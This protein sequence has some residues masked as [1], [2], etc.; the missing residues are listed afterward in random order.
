MDL[1][2]KLKDR[3]SWVLAH[4]ILRG[5][6]ILF[7]VLTFAK[8]ECDNVLQPDPRRGEGSNTIITPGLGNTLIHG[9]ECYIVIVIYLPFQHKC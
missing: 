4:V 8:P 7:R 1:V 2:V 5:Y 9:K 6:N 3:F